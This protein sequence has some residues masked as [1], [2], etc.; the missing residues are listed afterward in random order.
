MT[1]T[2]V[3]SVYSGIVSLRSLR[4]V[5]FLAEL[6]KLELWGADIGNAYLEA[7]IKEKVYII[8]GK[9]F[10]KLEGHTSVINKALYGLESS[11]LRWH[12]KFSDTLR[13]M[14]FKIS[15]A[16]SDVWMRKMKMFGNTLQ[17][18]LMI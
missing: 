12:E 4:L 11:G 17:Y 8:A 2:P 16:D 14:G 1:E 6:N 5:I 3:D 7:H 18:M 13:D 10:G 9:G 15:K